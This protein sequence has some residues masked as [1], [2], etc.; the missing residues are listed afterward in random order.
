LIK[1]E[2]PENDHISKASRVYFKEEA[3]EIMPTKNCGF[4]GN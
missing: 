4:I 2:L 3:K 1:S